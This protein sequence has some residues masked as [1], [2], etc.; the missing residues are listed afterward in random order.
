MEVRHKKV[1]QIHTANL[2][3]LGFG[4]AAAHLLPVMSCNFRLVASPSVQ[5]LI[6]GCIK[7][8]SFDMLGEPL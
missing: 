2:I 1:F 3:R 8:A 7:V 6:G 5:T 4:K